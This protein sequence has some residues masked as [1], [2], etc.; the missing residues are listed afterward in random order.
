MKETSLS[1][2]LPPTPKLKEGR[3]P[4]KENRI[5]SFLALVYATPYA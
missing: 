4:K 1:I 5:F 3:I 2:Q